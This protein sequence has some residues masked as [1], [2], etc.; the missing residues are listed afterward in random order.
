MSA[1]VLVVEADRWLQK[2]IVRRL[3][4]AGFAPVPASTWQEALKLVRLGLVVELIFLGPT[5]PLE[6]G[7]REA[8]VAQIPMIILP[9]DPWDAIDR[10]TDRPSAPHA[11]GPA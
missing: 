6:E 11:S 7:C 9:P 1:T 5:V 4:L 2:A 8:A 3:H 10:F